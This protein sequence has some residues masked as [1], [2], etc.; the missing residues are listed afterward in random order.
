MTTPGD[1]CLDAHRRRP[2]DQFHS[3]GV[4]HFQSGGIKG[5]AVRPSVASVDGAAS[6]TRREGHACT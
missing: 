1:N 3:G 2:V 6:G 5:R 4:D